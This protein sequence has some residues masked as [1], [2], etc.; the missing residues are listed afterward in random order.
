MANIDDLETS[1]QNLLQDHLGVDAVVGI[2]YTSPKGQKRYAFHTTKDKPA[3][4][5]LCRML[6]QACNEPTTIVDDSDDEE[7]D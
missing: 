5:E 4:R 3:L 7:E 2:C 6:W 1:I